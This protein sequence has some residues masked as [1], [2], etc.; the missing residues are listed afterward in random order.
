MVAW[1]H[2]NTPIQ[3]LNLLNDPTF[4]EASLALAQS[5]IKE[6]PEIPERLDAAFFRVLVRSPSEKEKRILLDFLDQENGRFK[7]DP[8]SV[9]A[10]LSNG[11]TLK[12]DP[13]IPPAELA[14]WTS[15]CRALLNLHETITRY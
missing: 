4:L 2:S 6:S 15:L 13:A 12:P 14:A 10:F 11:I 7:T 9:P 3:A 8:A 1:P 5:L